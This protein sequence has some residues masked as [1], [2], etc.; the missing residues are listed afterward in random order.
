MAGAEAVHP[1]VLEKAANDALD[2][3][4]LGQTGDARAQAA[5]PAHDEV[6]LDACLARF[7]ER[8]DDLP[9]DERV[10]LHPDRRPPARL[11]MG[12]VIADVDTNATRDSVWLQC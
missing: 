10:H 1:A 12:H 9:I 11:G 4:V 7:I 6:D 3:N 2:A 5:D 8:I